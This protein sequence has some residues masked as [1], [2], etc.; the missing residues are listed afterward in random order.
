MNDETDINEIT[1]EEERS[2][3]D[4]RTRRV[5]SVV[6]AGD[7]GA[8]RI[9]FSPDG[10]TFAV[11]RND[12]DAIVY[13]FR[14]GARIVAFTGRGSIADIDFSPNGKLLASAS[15]NGSVTLWDI[16]RRQKAADLTGPI[17]AAAVRFSPDG[18]LIAVGDSSGNVVLWEAARKTRLGEPL[19]AGVGIVT[20]L[21]FDRSGTT[22]VTASDD[23]KLRLWDVKTR[24]LIG[25]PLSAPPGIGSASFFPDGKHVVGVS[26]TGTGVVWTVDPAAWRARACL[27]AN[28][29]LTPDE[30]R[31][32]LPERSY[33][34]VCP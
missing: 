29:N 12:A 33:R 9:A 10:R 16:A 5:L 27:V 34:T 25:V 11:G 32:F 19:A 24:K 31:R 17:L 13:S 23:G 26:G 15:L 22:L 18:K 21:D 4:V 30:W 6:P 7:H 8:S 3:W 14:T 28:R 20:W 1:I 2:V